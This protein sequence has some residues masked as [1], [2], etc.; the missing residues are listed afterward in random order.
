MRKMEDGQPVR[1]AHSKPDPAPG[2][3][4]AVLEA[5]AKAARAQRESA[6]VQGGGVEG[7][8]AVPAPG[9]T[10]AAVAGES[11]AP[12]QGAH[13]AGAAKKKKK[14]LVVIIAAVVAC[15]VVAA[16]IAC[17]LAF[18]P[19]P[20]SEAVKVVES[21][22]NKTKSVN[23]ATV[24]QLVEEGAGAD[25]SRYGIDTAALVSWLQKDMSYKATE[26][27]EQNNTATVS[28]EASCHDMAQLQE[29]ITSVAKEA[30]TSADFQNITTAEDAYKLIGSKAFERAKS[31]EPASKSFEVK[32]VKKGET[33][34]L[35]SE[36]ESSIFLQLWE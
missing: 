29:C 32:V 36:D 25:L 19:A 16:G 3:D 15:L 13:S 26:L 6:S 27:S 9:T 17:F 23:A 33:W 21:A 5:I 24:A 35:L 4:A 8:H 28:V 31:Q 1:G 11:A 30:V 34:E 12:G 2:G 20:G 14:R 10:P 22:L 7:A 18:R